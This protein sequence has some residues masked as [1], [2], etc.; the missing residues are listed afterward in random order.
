MEVKELTL[1][2]IRQTI[3]DMRDDA[4]QKRKTADR[5]RRDNQLNRAFML[6]GEAIVIEHW[7]NRLNNALTHVK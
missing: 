3:A 2:E 7:V 6:T 5:Y 1:E 4:A